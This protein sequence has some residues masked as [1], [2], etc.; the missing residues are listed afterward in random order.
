ML[1][2]QRTALRRFS[3]AQSRPLDCAAAL[4]ALGDR[5]LVAGA[6]GGADAGHRAYGPLPLLSSPPLP[7]PPAAAERQ[8]PACTT[9]VLQPFPSAPHWRRERATAHAREAAGSGG[10]GPLL[11][12]GT[13]VHASLR[14]ASALR[15]SPLVLPR[16]SCHSRAFSDAAPRPP[17]G[18]SSEQPEASSSGRDGAG[19]PAAAAAGSAAPPAEDGA[20]WS[21]DLFNLPNSLSVARGLSGPLIAHW[22]LQARC[23]PPEDPPSTAASLFSQSPAYKT[24]TYHIARGKAIRALR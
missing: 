22:I 16:P 14:A 18:G 4:L 10:M 24:A 20:G 19:K 13:A 8:R 23:V 3:A 5:T 9:A 2:A 1:A 12:G 17:A 6:Q 15:S 21:M 7:P 11:G